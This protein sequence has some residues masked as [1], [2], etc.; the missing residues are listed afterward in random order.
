M[1]DLPAAAIG[2]SRR[3]SAPLQYLAQWRV[4]PAKE[5]LR[6]TGDGLT[7]I[8]GSVGYGSE[9]SFAAAFK[10]HV[11]LAPGRWRAQHGAERGP[12]AAG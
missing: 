12:S 2:S 1:S 7:A 8:A 10:R 4:A 6:D 9:F 11:G 5:R 3:P